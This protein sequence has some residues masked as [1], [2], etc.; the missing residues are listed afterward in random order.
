VVNVRPMYNPV[1]DTSSWKG[2]Q[3]GVRFLH[4][5]WSPKLTRTQE[6]P[7]LVGTDT[8]SATASVSLAAERQG[9]RALD[10]W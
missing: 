9:H 5:F 2:M 10:L 8:Y 7:T 4:N 1:T 3:R 6:N